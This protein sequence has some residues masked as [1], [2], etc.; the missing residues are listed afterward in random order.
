MMVSFPGII[1]A[2]AIAG[3][4]GP[5]MTNA[6]IAISSVLGLSMQDFQEVWFKI[7]RNFI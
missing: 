6:I 7:K 3:L 4:L 2:I 5:S 1:L